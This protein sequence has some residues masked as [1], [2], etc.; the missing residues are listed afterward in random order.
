M[1]T[2]KIIRSEARTKLRNDNWSTALSIFFTLFAS[3]LLVLFLQSFIVL[4]VQVVLS[5]SLHSPLK[6][7][8]LSA[9]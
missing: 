4:G 1:N 3:V 7:R 6:L 8:I 9:I 2:E 5:L